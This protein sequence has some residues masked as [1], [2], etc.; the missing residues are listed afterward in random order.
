M[1]GRPEIPLL[2]VPTHAR[3]PEGGGHTHTCCRCVGG[4]VHG[5]VS[6]RRAPGERAAGMKSGGPASPARGRLSRRRCPNGLG[7]AASPSEPPHPRPGPAGRARDG[8]RRRGTGTRRSRSPLGQSPGRLPRPLCPTDRPG[9]RKPGS[10]QILGE[11]P[12]RTE[13]G[14]A[15]GAEGG[16]TGTE[17]RAAENQSPPGPRQPRAA[18]PPLPALEGQAPGGRD[19]GG[20]LPRAEEE[21]RGRAA[22]SA[23]RNAPQTL[24]RR[25]RRP[26]RARGRAVCLGDRR[27]QRGDPGA[28]R[29]EAR[30]QCRGVRWPGAVALPP[31]APRRLGCQGLGTRRYYLET[32]RPLQPRAE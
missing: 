30:G 28:H 23:A 15:Q 13:L 3:P 21:G 24:T 29:D 10:A 7:P 22:G 9:S 14:R 16:R 1:L 4:F 11:R 31:P 27:R 26:V 32:E 8:A 12:R 6:G 17:T 5:C 19:A 18:P 2:P 25:W 20:L